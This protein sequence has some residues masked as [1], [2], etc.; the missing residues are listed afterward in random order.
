MRNIKAENSRVIYTTPGVFVDANGWELVMEHGKLTVKPV[1]SW[2]GYPIVWSSILMASSLQKLATLTDKAELETQLVTAA[3]AIL[4]EY[5]VEIRKMI[6]NINPRIDA[7]NIPELRYVYLKLFGSDGGGIGITG[8]GQ[9]VKVPGW[10]PE[11]LIPL[12]G[13]LEH[14]GDL[15][16]KKVLKA[17]LKALAKTILEAY[18]PELAQFAQKQVEEFVHA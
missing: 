6:G 18:T 7:G 5:S 8:D 12:V 2:D 9:I 16:E 13:G 17:R 11:S 10:T 4:T 1:P 14:F 15:T 3:N